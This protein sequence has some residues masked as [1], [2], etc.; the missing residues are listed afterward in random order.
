[1]LDGG[2][3]NRGADAMALAVCIRAD[4][5]LEDDNRR[6]AMRAFDEIIVVS[7]ISWQVH[8]LMAGIYDRTK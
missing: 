8:I 2:R 3:A 1:M 4:P 7:M 5:N 6:V